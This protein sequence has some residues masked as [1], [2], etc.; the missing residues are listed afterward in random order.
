MKK[1]FNTLR[2]NFR[3]ELR[4]IGQS[5]KSGAGKDDIYDSS[6]WFNDAMLFLRD[7]EIPSSS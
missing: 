7:Q 6:L 5:E 1:K 2:T 3:K 4:K